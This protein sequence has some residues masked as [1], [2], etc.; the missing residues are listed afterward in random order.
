MHGTWHCAINIPSAVLPV[1]IEAIFT[2]LAFS[3]AALSYRQAVKVRRESQARLV[4]SSLVA[5]ELYGPGDV[6]DDGSAGA[7]SGFAHG[8]VAVPLGPGAHG[9]Q[10]QAVKRC[11][12]V[13]VRIHNGSK[14]LIGPAKLQLID[15]STGALNW[16][17]AHRTEVVDPESDEL[18]SLIF[19]DLSHPNVPS[20]GTT[21]I[22]R[23]ASGSCWRRD[24]SEP[25][26]RA[27]RDPENFAALPKERAAS[28]AWSKAAGLPTVPEPSVPIRARLHRLGRRL[29]GR[30]PLP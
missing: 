25:V 15:P 5:L 11:V 1:W 24:R 22:F 2:S 29:S 17:F 30:T 10:W 27:H 12:H 6:F 4:Y 19:E 13:T 8:G 28:N 9:A 7:T 16:E 18:A 14:E 20:V 23:D 21:V 3:V 26:V